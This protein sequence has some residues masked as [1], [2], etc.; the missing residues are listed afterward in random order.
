METRPVAPMTSTVPSYISICGPNSEAESKSCW[1]ALPLELAR[2]QVPFTHLSALGDV[3]HEILS[4]TLNRLPSGSKVHPVSPLVQILKPYPVGV[5]VKL[6][7]L[8]SACC[9]VCEFEIIHWPFG[10]TA[11]W[12]SPIEV[13]PAGGRMG[14]H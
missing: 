12:A 4:S 7:S 14:S 13:Q 8:N 10:R 1:G 9:C 3:P 6:F 11:L 2:N 5:K